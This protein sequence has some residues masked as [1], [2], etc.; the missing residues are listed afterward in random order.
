[1]IS[2]YFAVAALVVVALAL[3]LRPWW[4]ASRRT[5]SADSLPAL[6][7]AIHRDRLAELERDRSSGTLSAA[8]LAEAREELQRQLIDD[9]AAVEVAAADGFGR[10]SAITIAILLPLIAI[11]LYALLGSPAAVLPGEVQ[12]QRATADLE[13][14]TAK[15]AAKME[16]NPDN[17]EGWAML[18][19]SY[20][21]LG[22]WDDAERAFTRIGPD[23]NKNAE[24]LAEL[25]E[26]LVQK[27]NGFDDR[28]RQL[29]QQALRLEPNNMLALFLGGGN[30]VAGGRY[31]EAAAL[32]QRLLPQLEPGSEDAQ[33]V[34]ANIAKALERS[35]GA[36]PGAPRRDVP[37][38]AVAPQDEAHR[39]AG[40]KDKAAAKATGK[41]VSG[42]VELSPALKAKANPDDVVFIFA[43]AVDGP[44]MPLAALRARAA[45][46]PL[47]FV[48]DDSQAVMPTA[49][50]SS[51]EQVRVEVRISKTGQATP[52]KGDLTGKSAAVK[53]GAKGLRIVIDQVTP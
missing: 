50:I 10:R 3:L 11:G 33:M 22:R 6:N 12:T 37:A 15:L 47:D 23:L 20:K 43:R 41:S 31:A 25:A 49:N 21:S 29:I 27:N 39:A 13:Q 46:L 38:G 32:W 17:P 40:S 42:R 18:A 51:A 34:E 7:A 45:D 52:G 2:F 16:Q 53:P 30:A 5:V 8:D 24:L 44:R 4:R 26:M 48:L 19:R 14:L 9:T 35:G 28:S 36:K 1:M